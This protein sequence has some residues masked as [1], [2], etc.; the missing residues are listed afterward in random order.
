MLTA[1]GCARWCAMKSNIIECNDSSNI[2]WYYHGVWGVVQWGTV[3]SNTTTRKV[4][5]PY[6]LYLLYSYCVNQRF[7]WVGDMAPGCIACGLGIAGASGHGQVRLRRVPSPWPNHAAPPKGHRTRSL[8]THCFESGGRI[9]S[10]SFGEHK[11]SHPASPPNLLFK[12]SSL[13]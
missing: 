10:V 13:P 7:W 8:R 4:C 6:L 12:M 2:I 3:K 5:T 9:V 11:T 1:L